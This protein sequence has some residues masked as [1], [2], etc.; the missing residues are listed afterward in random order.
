MEDFRI[1]YKN[2]NYKIKEFMEN[3]ENSFEEEPGNEKYLIHLNNKLFLKIIGNWKIR[4]N[5]K[6]IISKFLVY[7]NLRRDIFKFENNL[8]CSINHDK[9]FEISKKIY[10]N[11][12]DHLYLVKEDIFSNYV[13]DDNS[14]EELMEGYESTI[15]IYY[16]D[17]LC[18]RINLNLG[19]EE[20]INKNIKYSD[21]MYWNPSELNLPFPKNYECKLLLVYF[22]IKN[23]KQITSKDICRK[24]FNILT[25][26]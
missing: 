26:F 23:I 14:I 8:L 2:Q 5:K 16:F 20:I 18:I 25:G 1:L 24:V 13:K 7:R 9:Y 3:Q 12:N 4:R 15:K 21:C 6:P 22:L 17:N 19:K 10:I 11:M